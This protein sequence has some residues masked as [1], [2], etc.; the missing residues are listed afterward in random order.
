MGSPSLKSPV[1]LLPPMFYPPVN[2]FLPTTCAI[3][4]DIEYE[5]TVPL[6]LT[7]T[8]SCLSCAAPMPADAPL[9]SNSPTAAP[10]QPAFNN[11]DDLPLSWAPLLLPTTSP[12]LFSIYSASST[13]TMNVPLPLTIALTW[14]IQNSPNPNPKLRQNT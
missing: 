7:P 8:H 5:Q 3:L 9:P 1:I 4:L 14:Q 11:Y 12:E 2:P 6:T 10:H 13:T